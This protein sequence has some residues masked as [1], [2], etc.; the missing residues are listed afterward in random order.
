MKR[1]NA[2]SVLAV[3]KKGGVVRDIIPCVEKKIFENLY[4]YS[5]SSSKYLQ[6]FMG[7]LVESLNFNNYW[8]KDSSITLSGDKKMKRE[9]RP[10]VYP[11][12]H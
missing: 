8:K 1:E 7:N 3:V 4:S 12:K 11:G 10:R 9:N 5:T 2:R 6:G